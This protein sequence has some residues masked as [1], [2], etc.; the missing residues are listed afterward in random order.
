MKITLY[1][2][3]IAHILLFSFSITGCGRYGQNLNIKQRNNIKN[4]IT[5]DLLN[6]KPILTSCKKYKIQFIDS[7]TNNHKALVDYCLDKDL[8]KT[9]T[10]DIIYENED[11]HLYNFLSF[12]KKIQQS[13]LHAYHDPKTNR[14]ILYIGRKGKGGGKRKDKEGNSIQ[15]LKKDLEENKIYSQYHK[16]QILFIATFKEELNKIELSLNYGADPICIVKD[17]ISAFDLAFHKKKINIIRQF[18]NFNK[19]VKYAKSLKK[20]YPISISYLNAY[21]ASLLDKNILK[22]NNNKLLDFTL[23]NQFID[24][25]ILDAVNNNDIDKIK[26]YFDEC[27]E[28]LNQNNSNIYEVYLYQIFL[29]N[30]I[31]IFDLLLK[32]GA[33][34]SSK[35]RYKDSIFQHCLLKENHEF[36]KKIIEHNNRIKQ[37]LELKNKS[38]FSLDYLKHI[39]DRSYLKIDTTLIDFGEEDPH[40]FN[41]MMR[42]YD[43]DNP[44]FLKTLLKEAKIHPDTYKFPNKL[45][46]LNQACKDLLKNDS[47]NLR[48]K[49]K[50]LL[51]NG[52]DLNFKVNDETYSPYELLLKKRD[53]ELLDLAKKYDSKKL[54]KEQKK[55]KIKTT[56]INN[57]A[58]IVLNLIKTV[59]DASI[60]INGKPLIKHAYDNR[61]N[62]I[63]KKLLDLGYKP[64]NYRDPN[65]KTLLYHSCKDNNT[66]VAKW[67]IEKGANPYLELEEKADSNLLKNNEVGYNAIQIAAKSGSWETL[68]F[69]KRK[70]KTIDF[71]EAKHEESSPFLLAYFENQLKTVN[72]FLNQTDID[73]NKS[74]DKLK[75][76]VLHD[77]CRKNKNDL[78]NILLKSN[79]VKPNTKALDRNTALHYAT[80]NSYNGIIETF[81]KSDNP[82]IDFN[83]TNSKNK[84]PFE[85]AC[86]KKNYKGAKLLSK[87]T[88]F[89]KIKSIKKKKLIRFALGNKCNELLKIYLESGFDIKEFKDDDGIS[90]YWN[91]CNNNNIE[92]IDL[93]NKYGNDPDIYRDK[94]NRT[95]LKVAFDNN[96][97][98]RIK[99]LLDNK[100][101]IDFTKD[102]SGNTILHI[103]TYKGDIKMVK[104]LLKYADKKSILKV[105]KENKS[106]IQI[107]E[108]RNDIEILN[109]FQKLRKNNKK[110]FS[111]KKFF[112]MKLLALKG[113]K[114]KMPNL[115]TLNNACNGL[116]KKIK[117]VININYKK[118]INNYISSFKPLEKQS[119]KI[120]EKSTEEIIKQIK[121]TK[122][123][124]S[125][126]NKKVKEIENLIAK[127]YEENKSPSNSLKNNAS[128]IFSNNTNNQEKVI[129][130]SIK[131]LALSSKTAKFE[132]KIL[133]KLINLFFNTDD[134]SIKENI[135]TIII[136]QFLEIENPSVFKIENKTLINFLEHSILNSNNRK[137]LK[138]ARILDILVN[139]KYK[140]SK[141]FINDYEARI[142]SLQKFTKVKNLLKSRLK[143]DIENELKYSILRFLLKTQ[144]LYPSI[145]KNYDPADWIYKSLIQEIIEKE[146]I[147][148]DEFKLSRFYETLNVIKKIYTKKEIKS[149]LSILNQK[150]QVLNLD[151]TEICNCLDFLQPKSI[152]GIKILYQDNNTSWYKDLKF[153]WIENQI[154]T[155]FKNQKQKNH[156]ELIKKIYELDLETDI[157]KD[158]FQ[159]IKKEI[160]MDGLN[161]SIPSTNNDEKLTTSVPTFSKESFKDVS[162]FISY[163]SSLRVKESENLDYNL[164]LRDTFRKNYDKDDGDGNDKENIIKLWKINIQN[165][166]LKE[167]IKE[168]FGSKYQ[169]LFP[170]LSTIL[171]KHTSYQLIKEFLE[172]LKKKDSP[173]IEQK[174]KNLF[175]KIEEYG[176]N[177]ETSENLLKKIVRIEPDNWQ[178]D[179]H[180]IIINGTFKESK[181]RKIDDLIEFISDKNKEISFVRDKDQLKSTFEKIDEYYKNKSNILSNNRSKISKWREKDIKEWAIAY[182]KLG[183]KRLYNSS[184]VQA[185]SLAVLR[186]AVYLHTNKY[187]PRNIQQLAVLVLLNR[188]KGFG[189]LAQV[190]TGEGKSL[191]VAM[192]ATLKSLQGYKVD[193]VTTS[194]E[195]SKPDSEGFQPFYEMFNLTVAE[196]SLAKPGDYEA[197]KKIYS[198]DIVYGTTNNFQGDILKDEYLGKKIRCDRG[199]SLVI[200]DEVDSMLIDGNS[201]STQLTSPKPAMDSLAL[202]LG[203]IWNYVRIIWA[204]MVQNEYGDW[205]YC[206]KKFIKKNDKIVIT[207][208]YDDIEKVLTPIPDNDR[209]E[210]IK[211]EAV[212]YIKNLLRP[213]K[214]KEKEAW[215]ELKKEN[216]AYSRKKIKIELKRLNENEKK[217]KLEELGKEH[218]EK[219]KNQ[220]WKK[221]E[222]DPRL[223][224]P[225]HLRDFC[226][227]QTPNWVG[228]ALHA[229]LYYERGR[230]YEIQEDTI[231]PIDAKDTGSFNKNMVYSDAL[232]QFLQIKHGLRI[233]PESLTPSF[234]S[235]VAFFKR[236]GKNIYGLTGTLGSK[237]SQNLLSR[238]YKT[239]IVILPPF[240]NIEIISNSKSPYLCKELPA[241]VKSNEDEWKEEIC[242]NTIEKLKNN[243]A[244]LLICQYKNKAE[245]I[246]NLLTDKYRYSK[247]KVF[248]YTGAKK[249]KKDEI[250]AGEVIVATNISG[251]GTDLETTKE[252]EATGGLHVCDTFLPYNLRIELQNI[253]RTA[254]KGQRGTGQLIILDP[255]NRDIETIKKERNEKEVETLKKA[256][257]S[258][259]RSRCKSLLGLIQ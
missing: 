177:K 5:L 256:E 142:L 168:L 244:V 133:N 226:I 209:I 15:K 31:K 245:E 237:G 187:E 192:L 123:F 191:I 103:A 1:H 232:C 240:K 215:Q 235:N 17:D 12:D 136:N 221:E 28:Y 32:N 206:S 161:K 196:N 43:I 153:N 238:E 100:A 173:Y 207:E 95:L 200:V 56:Y 45:T 29:D 216:E 116:I 99:K 60:K 149:I 64:D 40:G 69:L 132:K 250:K 159:K 234:I 164:I 30:K 89:N 186:R 259:Q 253:G 74:I 42:A 160:I 78:V 20:D 176:I 222:Y 162:D 172:Y 117:S 111:Y 36:F 236:Y 11:H 51:E 66:E 257:K 198:S 254:R 76:T 242:K 131:I 137:T 134:T 255:Q 129:H 241:I 205:Y 189:R 174:L 46:L 141:E 130:N 120:Q 19:K 171:K 65:N 147:N 246:A 90:L 2:R 47:D 166:L 163:V 194:V 124:G 101:K 220:K 57:N 18:L 25:F 92:L 219:Q 87:K 231:V 113:I 9:E 212:G 193:I 13:R 68:N 58:K 204:N 37:I 49:I 230:Q 84:T 54:S 197:K 182:K 248:L 121:S 41:P 125:K 139:K 156:S 118:S 107:A 247:D 83:I 75:R 202:L 93:L 110:N 105:N 249:F 91:A 109:L 199:N 59:E 210:Y 188:K 208:K 169:F 122:I 252:V 144:K 33:N 104:L 80:E 170:A 62:L 86:Y 7:K 213:I 61:D 3:I 157:L 10:W 4:D 225:E 127:K 85:I 52:A 55:S 190:N 150:R 79:K 155:L 167:K 119:V 227:N 21:L 146:I 23:D 67:L 22:I 16:N 72:F 97:L 201:T 35:G 63:I 6:T 106:A 258:L 128:N 24:N 14:K 143:Y 96:K 203:F 181:E 82:N 228:S 38:Y 70:I 126:L 217:Q 94:K 102:S 71:N 224:I 175:K 158:F 154:Q 251:R 165:Y 114:F 8:T 34:P 115:N 88:D 73:P 183:K 53:S 239:D 151:L 218:K 50:L 77:A 214:N 39:I 135:R 211:K 48:K 44:K 108:E 223:D 81:V 243:R 27:Q 179:T 180:K 138:F 195:L 152:K 145:L 26:F 184:E 148:K 229:F 185:E 98:I 112:Y 233:T 178:K 140:I